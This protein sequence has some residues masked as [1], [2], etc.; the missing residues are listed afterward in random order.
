MTPVIEKTAN[1]IRATVLALMPVRLSV[2]HRRTVTINVQMT[3]LVCLVFSM[4]LSISRWMVF[5]LNGYIVL[6]R[7]QPMNNKR[8]TS[9]NMNSIH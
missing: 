2:S 5:W 4:L 7:N 1:G 8:I 6:S 3:I 9:G